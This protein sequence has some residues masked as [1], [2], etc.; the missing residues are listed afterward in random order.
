MKRILAVCGLTLVLAS[1]PSFGQSLSNSG[2]VRGSILDPSSAAVVGASVQIQNPISHFARTV[3][4]DGQGRFEF[5]N[6]PYNNYHFSIQPAGFQSAEQDVDVRSS[7]ALDLK[8][9]MKLGTSSE[10]VT[11]V[12]AGDLVENDPTIH[13]DVVLILRLL[14]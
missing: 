10:S 1:I 12:A 9:G 7:V 3:V 14:S 11:V 6:I 2:T 8:I 13:T 5:D 4:T